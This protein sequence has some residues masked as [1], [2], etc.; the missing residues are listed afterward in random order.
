MAEAFGGLGLLAEDQK[1]VSTKAT[2]LIAVSML[3]KKLSV[4][5]RPLVRLSDS[6]YIVST[7][8]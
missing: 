2:V 3:L 6:V 1:Y 4:F 8:R 5:I 7:K